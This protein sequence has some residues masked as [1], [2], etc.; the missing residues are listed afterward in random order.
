[1]DCVG[2]NKFWSEFPSFLEWTY[3]EDE[4]LITRSKRDGS[5]SLARIRT[6]SSVD[7]SM[8]SGIFSGSA[9]TSADGKIVII[10]KYLSQKQFNSS[11]QNT[12][13]H[14]Q[15]H[16]VVNFAEQP[17][18]INSLAQFSLVPTLILS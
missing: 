15:K 1:M 10:P 16:F 2:A 17:S 6:T 18:W 11:W 3:V 12:T 14:Y 13:I 9:N 5:V 4:D 7:S 8:E